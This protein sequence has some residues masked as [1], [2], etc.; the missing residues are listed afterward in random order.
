MKRIKLSFSIFITTIFIVFFISSCNDTQ[1]VRYN[2]EKIYQHYKKTLASNPD[3]DNIFNAVGKLVNYVRN[4]KTKIKSNINIEHIKE[5]LKLAKNKNSQIKILSKLTNRPREF[6]NIIKEK[7]KY[8]QKFIAN[9]SKFATLSHK[10]QKQ[11]I[12]YAV[13][14]KL[15][16]QNVSRDISSVISHTTRVA[17]PG[18][19]GRCHKHAYA[20]AAG[21]GLLS[22]TF[23]GALIC[24]GVVLYAEHLCLKGCDAK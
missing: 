14:K 7:Y 5:E 8:Q 16:K 15:N 22:E 24:G 21:C 19:R 12:T 11:L 9:N 3:F 23:F 4:P 6:Y 20:E 13:E 18:C 1:S 2:K 10:K 17:T